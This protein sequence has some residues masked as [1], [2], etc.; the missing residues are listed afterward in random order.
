MRQI[1]ATKSALKV[2]RS[3]GPAKLLGMSHDALAAGLKKSE[4]L[5][6]E[7]NAYVS[8]QPADR[9]RRGECPQQ[10]LR[11]TGHESDLAHIE[12]RVHDSGE[13]IFVTEWFRL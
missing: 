11:Q 1:E 7:S 3:V 8:N 4:S 2:S 12:Q 10:V 9:L 5:L 6:T 13:Q